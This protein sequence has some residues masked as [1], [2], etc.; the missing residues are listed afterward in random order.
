[1]TTRAVL[2][3]FSRRQQLPDFR[4]ELPPGPSEISR[5]LSALAEAKPDV[6]LLIAGV[7]DAARLARAVRSLSAPTATQPSLF[8][9]PI[10]FANQSAARTRFR[11]LAGDA[12]EGLR[13]PVLAA[14]PG[15]TTNNADAAR[16]F[17]EFIAARGHP[18]DHATLLTY[19]ATRLLVEAIRQAGPDRARVRAALAHL[20]PWPGIAGVIHFDGTGQNTRAD[21]RLAT[22]RN[23][24]LEPSDGPAD[25]L[26]AHHS[27]PP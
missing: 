18:P 8:P 26:T 17:N 9:A 12:A 19:D 11:E 25:P 6:V 22:L 2:R 21:L 27:T 23:G 15:N 7:E 3:E 10:L 14:P 16:F 24:R 1:M 4:F 20:S 5:H 13:F